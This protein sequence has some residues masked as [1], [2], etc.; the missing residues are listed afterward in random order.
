MTH[1]FHCSIARYPKFLI[2]R[3]PKFL[4]KQNITWWESDRCRGSLSDFERLRPDPP[5]LGRD[6]LCFGGPMIEA[7]DEDCRR[8]RLL[9]VYIIICNNIGINFYYNIKKLDHFH[10]GWKYRFEKWSSFFWKVW[11]VKTVTWCFAGRV[12]SCGSSMHRW[13][14]LFQVCVEHLVSLENKIKSENIE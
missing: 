13:K 4:L 2:A 11:T 10:M 9:N 3:Y 5:S 1:D 14:V 7:R 8:D 12:D 6:I